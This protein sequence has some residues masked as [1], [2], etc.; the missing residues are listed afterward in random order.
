MQPTAAVTPNLRV[1]GSIQKVTHHVE[2]GNDFAAAARDALFRGGVTLLYQVELP[3]LD[4]C[5][6]T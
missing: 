1:A 4:G 2:S 6:G 5:H 3:N